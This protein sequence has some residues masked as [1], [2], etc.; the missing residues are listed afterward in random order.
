MPAFPGSKQNVIDPT[1]VVPIGGFTL[2][3]ASA[4]LRFDVTGPLGVAVFCD[5]SN[6]SS[7]TFDLDFQAIRLSCG[8]G[9][10][11]DTPVGPVRLDVALRI[12]PLQVFPFPDESAAFNAN[13]TWGQPTRIFGQPFNLAFGIGEAF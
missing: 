7:N 3:E 4:E 2:W 12:Q 10:R 8:A 13:N 9:G 1:C 6:V 11:Y 5:S